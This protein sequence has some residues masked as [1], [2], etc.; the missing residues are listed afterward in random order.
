LA[1][2]YFTIYFKQTNIEIPL[3]EIQSNALH[4]F[5][6]GNFGKGD[7]TNLW[8]SVPLDNLKITDRSV[9]PEKLGYAAAKHKVYLEATSTKEGNIHLKFHPTKK[10]YYMDR[11]I[12]E[13]YKA[14]KKRDRAIRKARRGGVLPK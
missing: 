7:A 3:L 10:K 9:I 2:P 6:E 12:L 5:V 11:G 13:Q 14:D 1:L 4:L 8:L